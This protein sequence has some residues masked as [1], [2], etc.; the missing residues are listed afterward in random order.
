[1][2][3]CPLLG[4]AAG[5]AAMRALERLGWLFKD[6][7]AARWSSRWHWSSRAS[8]AIQLHTHD[9]HAFL[10]YFT[11]CATKPAHPYLRI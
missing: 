8:S 10:P 7:M 2:S 11:H 1:M 6:G 5:G 4:H 3:R 9:S